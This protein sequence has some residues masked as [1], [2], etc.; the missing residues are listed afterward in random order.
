VVIESATQFQI[1]ED[2]M[3]RAL[4]FSFGLVLI[5]LTKV[6]L[7]FA[8]DPLQQI[9]P[10]LGAIPGFGGAS[11]VGNVITGALG[12]GGK[13]GADPDRGNLKVSPLRI[14]IFRWKPLSDNEGKLVVLVGPYDIT[15]KVNGQTGKSVGPSNG[16]GTTTRFP[17]PGCAYGMARVEFFDALGRPVKNLLGDF[18]VS[19]PGCAN[20]RQ[21]YGPGNPITQMIDM[22]PKE[23][24]PDERDL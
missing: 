4:V 22:L 7:A 14:N 13:P 9:A 6:G 23:E 19:V 11:G 1:L 2:V 10:N 17:M 16:Y 12:G 5:G 3:T 18:S 21:Y 8:L 20:I 24:K 15:I